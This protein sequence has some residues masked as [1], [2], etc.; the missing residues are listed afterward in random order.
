[1]LA[2]VVVARPGMAEGKMDFGARATSFSECEPNHQQER[3]SEKGTFWNTVLP[4]A[5]CI[6]DSPAR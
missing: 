1:M 5:G 2:A 4:T 6:W 3:G